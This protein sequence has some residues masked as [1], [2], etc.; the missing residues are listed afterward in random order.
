MAA[1]E[2]YLTKQVARH[3]VDAVELALVA[4]VRTGVRVLHE[5]VRLAVTAERLLAV[6]A[7]DGVLQDVVAD[8]ADQL[9]QE[10]LD[11]L[12]VMYPILLVDVLL[13]LPGLLDDALHF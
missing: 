10:G 13:F 11:V 12:R 9:R 7:L 6:L 8:T 5:P 2:L 1:P 3:P 4:A